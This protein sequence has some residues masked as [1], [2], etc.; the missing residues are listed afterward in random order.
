[1]SDLASVTRADER[2]MIT[3]RGD[4]SSGKMKKAVKA[5]TGQAVPT[6]G[7]F[8]GN[9]DKGVAWMSP[10]EMLILS[11]SKRRGGR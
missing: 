11:D 5:A 10:D 9:N 2:G 7:Q 1:M 6:T 3:L 8:L 4:L